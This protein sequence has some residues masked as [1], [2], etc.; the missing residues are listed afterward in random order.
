MAY[1]QS[2][3]GCLALAFRS[4]PALPGRP[5]IS[6][7]FLDTT[8]VKG[9]E[10]EVNIARRLRHLTII[11]VA[12]VAIAPAT[13]AA[14]DEPTVDELFADESSDDEVATDELS[15]GEVAMDYFILRPLALARLAVGIPFFVVSIPFVALRDDG[16]KESRDFFIDE[17]LESAFKRPI[18]DF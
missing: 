11:L 15:T 5:W 14:A 4:N 16:F 1:P 3:T 6:P 18:G 13:P 9:M 2:A 8:A 17:P 10:I 7:S 12:L